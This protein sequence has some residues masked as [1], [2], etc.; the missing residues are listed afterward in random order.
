MTK[1]SG[2]FKKGHK[3]LPGSGM[4]K[5]MKT[6]ITLE[7]KE[8][9]DRMLPP[10]ELERRWRMLLDHK[11]PWIKLRAFELALQY[12]YGKPRGD[13]H[14]ESVADDDAPEIIDISA[15]PMPKLPPSKPS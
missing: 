5:G 13:E 6:Y 7:I 11:N 1:N 4:R 14:G 3:K 8:I 9:L 2:S 10:A 15:I 12:R